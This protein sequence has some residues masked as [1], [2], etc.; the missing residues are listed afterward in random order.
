M[1]KILESV[2]CLFGRILF[3]S[4]VKKEE[5]TSEK[6]KNISTNRYVLGSVFPSKT[7]MK[8]VK[9]INKDYKEGYRIG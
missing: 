8:Q 6:S 1:A 4:F 2:T 3:Y 9:R 5:D 7:V